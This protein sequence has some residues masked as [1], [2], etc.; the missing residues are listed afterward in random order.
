[1][2]TLVTGGAGF[3]GSH[4]VDRLLADGHTVIVIDNFRTGRWENLA[5]HLN[6][7]SL[8]VVPADVTHLDA[9]QPHFQGVEWVF[10]IAALADIVP[11]VQQ[12]LDYHRA[13]VDG[14]VTTLEAA[15]AAGVQRFVYSASSSCYGIPDVYPT[16][17]TAP[18]VRSIRMLSRNIWASS[19]SCT[20]GKSTVYQ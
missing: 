15:R 10:H 6:N 5:S 4:L 1:M 12:P 18:S 19:T 11:S 20:G 14:T 13:N 8:R 2:K 7:S 9:I 3:I 17:E 16:P